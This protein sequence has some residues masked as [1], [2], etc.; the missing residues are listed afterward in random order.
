MKN[1]GLWA[2]WKAK[3]KSLLIQKSNRLE[4]RCHNIKKSII[5]RHLKGYWWG[6]QSAFAGLPIMQIFGEYSLPLSS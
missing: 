4:E 1:Q 6:T 2:R 5:R 3:A